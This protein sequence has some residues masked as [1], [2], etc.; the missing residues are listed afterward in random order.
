[1]YDPEILYFLQSISRVY[2]DK[3]QHIVIHCPYCDDAT[4]DSSNV[5][6]YGHLYISKQLPVFYCHRCSIAGSILSLLRLFKYD[7]KEKLEKLSSHVKLNFKKSYKLKII[8]KKIEN[9]SFIKQKILNCSVDHLNL[10]FEYIK[11]RLGVINIGKFYIYPDYIN[12]M[13][14]ISFLNYNGQYSL[15]RYI[16]NKSTIRYYKGKEFYFFQNINNLENYDNIIITEGPFDLLNLYIYNKWQNTLYISINGKNYLNIIEELRYGE[17]FEKD[18]HLVFDSDNIKNSW[19]YNFENVFKWKT[20][21]NIKDVGEY[22]KLV[23]IS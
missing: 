9:K 4:R 8:N 12:S 6:K 22:P 11:L 1:M 13:Q 23:S 16:S 7:N 17:L 5:E 14:V 20:I 2:D 15:S 3:N 21:E 19:K 10:F 18:I